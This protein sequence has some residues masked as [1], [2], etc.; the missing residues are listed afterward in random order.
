MMNIV[1][2]RSLLFV[3][4][5]RNDRFDR[6]ATSGA[7]GVILDLEDS[8]APADKTAART[9]VRSWLD[10]GSRPVSGVV[11]RVNAVGTP[12]HDA[13]LRMVAAAGCAVLLPK[14]D[15]VDALRSVRA[16][17]SGQRT[18]LALIETARG[19]C[20]VASLCCSRLI[21]RAAFGSVDL[22]VELG[23]DPVSASPTLA[24]ARSALVMASAAAGLPQPLDAVT[25]AVDDLGRLAADLEDGV[26][27]GFGGKLAIHPRQ[28]EPIN[29]AWAPASAVVSWAER[30]IA[31][32]FTDGI[33]HALEGGEVAVGITTVDGQMVDVPVITR[34]RQILARAAAAAK[35]PTA[36]RTTASNGAP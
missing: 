16:E 25:T 20:D 6:A 9:A 21:D 28:I 27:I 8:V 29:S 30:V 11:V 1:E 13:D 23:L 24:Y 2:A 7:D 33:D 14:A 17:L 31:A 5:T 36:A 32:A 4:G 26:S 34:A 18:L 10:A 35:Q 3:P 19:V 15:T 22:A 12:W